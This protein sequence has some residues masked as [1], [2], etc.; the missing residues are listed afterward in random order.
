VLTQSSSGEAGQAIGLNAVDNGDEAAMARIM[1]DHVNTHG[2]L[3]GQKLVPVYYNIDTS[4]Y[5]DSADVTLSAACSFFTEDHHVVA[6]LVSWHARGLHV[7]EACMQRKGA[8]VIDPNGQIVGDR[9]ATRQYPLYMAPN[10]IGLDRVGENLPGVLAGAGYFSGAE[11]VGVLA[12]D[13]PE[14]HRTVDQRLKPALSRVR[15]NL[16][17]VVYISQAKSLS[18]VGRLSNELAAAVLRF[19]NANITRVVDLAGAVGLFAPQAESQRYRPRY[20]L[21]SGSAPAALTANGTPPAQ[22]RGAVGMGW[23]PVYDVNQSTPADRGPAEAACL[24]LMRARGQN[25]GSAITVIYTALTYCEQFWFLQHLAARVPAS[26]PLTGRTL[27]SALDG[28]QGTFRSSLTART[29]LQAD[30]PD[31]VAAV[32]RLAFHDSCECFRYAAGPVAA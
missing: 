28:V 8:A 29:L 17:D 21:T 26:S 16:K 30:R 22:L 25:P 5:G 11:P 10:G 7:F 1:V 24:A 20:G 12:M 15:A 9:F 18:D 14:M 23:M 27:A 2:G 19:R 4:Q 6:A 3:A 32:R 13:I 31:G